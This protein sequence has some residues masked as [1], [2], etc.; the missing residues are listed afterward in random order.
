MAKIEDIQKL[1]SMT[2]AGF[3]SCKDALLECEHDL[4]KAV[5]I[6][7]KAGLAIAATKSSRIA[8]EGLIVSYIHTGSKIGVLLELNC[9]TDFVAK[10]E[11]FQNLAHDIAMQLASAAA[12]E[13]ISIQ[14]IPEEVKS[15]EMSIQADKEDIKNKPQ[16]VKDKIIEGRMEKRLKELS[17]MDQ[18]FIKNP[19]ISIEE[20][21]KQNIAA[22]GENIQLRRFEKFIVGQE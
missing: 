7:R 3:K 15:H 17:L 10:D 8:R 6:L 20:L 19:D 2:G 12:V 18:D 16:N 5:N 21:I 9:E 13:Y 1:R 4:E 11:K 22:I 14:D